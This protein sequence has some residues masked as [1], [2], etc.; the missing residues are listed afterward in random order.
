MMGD[1]ID[2]ANDTA[3]FFLGVALRN[4]KPEPVG[5]CEFCEDKP[6]M[7][8]SNGC[9]GRYCEECAPI[10]LAPVSA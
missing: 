1:I 2:Q 6:R 7:R 9:T 3:E 4:V 5:P 8:Y 10:A